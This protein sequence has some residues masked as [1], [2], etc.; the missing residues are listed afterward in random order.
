MAF[1][2]KIDILAELKSKGYNS[3][4]I[5]K[6]K[7]MGEGMLQKIR[8]GEMPSWAVLD[9]VCTLLELPVGEVIEHIPDS[10]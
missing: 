8:S 10:E 6:E 2:Y 1:K 5:R 9:K 7:I 3:Y 4:T